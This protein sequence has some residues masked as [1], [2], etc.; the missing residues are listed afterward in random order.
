[1]Y[2]TIIISI[3]IIL[4][5]GGMIWW[6][7]NLENN[8]PDIISTNG[9]HLHP[10]LDIYVKGEKVAIPPNIGIGFKYSSFPTYDKSM[11]MTA[12]H[13]HDDVNQGIIHLEFSGKVGKQDTKL[14]NFFEIW[15][16]NMN[17][18]GD[19]VKMTV[20][21]KDTPELGDYLMKDG[22]KIELR[23]E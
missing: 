4:F 7:K 21:G 8:N 11:S 20:N 2:K 22:D 12:I 9:L 1:M 16:Q 15:G 19:N 23:Y 18:F 14:S 13:T 10:I 3:L 5:L 17:A 6:S